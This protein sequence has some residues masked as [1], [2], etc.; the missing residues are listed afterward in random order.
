[1]TLESLA[2]AIGLD[3]GIDMKN[4]AGNLPPVR[5][6]GLS[7]QKPQIRDDVLLVVSRQR[8]IRGS[9][10]RN[11]G[12]KRWCLHEISA[13]NESALTTHTLTQRSLKVAL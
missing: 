12:I 9:Q 4:E 5:I 1:M 10:V 7:V 2:S 3:D 11:I 13:R 6:V 8:R